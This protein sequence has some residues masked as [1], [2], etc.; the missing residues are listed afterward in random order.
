MVDITNEVADAPYVS[1][2]FRCCTL[3]QEEGKGEY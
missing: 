2:E 3:V 1:P